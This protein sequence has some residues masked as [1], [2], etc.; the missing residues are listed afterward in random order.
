MAGEA[1]RRHLVVG[2]GGQFELQQFSR[3][4]LAGTVLT[5][6]QHPQRCIA[7][8]VAIEGGAEGDLLHLRPSIHVPVDLP[9]RSA[10]G[11]DYL[12]SVAEAAGTHVYLFGV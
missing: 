4:L 9:L 3:H 2:A 10:V 6:G 8:V 5:A 12:R 11:A 1:V 7:G